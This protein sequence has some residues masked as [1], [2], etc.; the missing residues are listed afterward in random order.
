M[1]NECWS[2]IFFEFKI[3]FIQ[4]KNNVLHINLN[5]NLHF[6]DNSG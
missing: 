5:L 3:Y 4:K 1:K 6:L 2:C